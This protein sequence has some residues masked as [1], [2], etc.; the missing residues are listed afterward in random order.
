[1]VF[2]INSI[3]ESSWLEPAK[4]TVPLGQRASIH[5]SYPKWPTLFSR[6]H[7]TWDEA[8]CSALTELMQAAVTSNHCGQHT[9]NHET[10]PTRLTLPDLPSTARLT[11]VSYSTALTLPASVLRIAG[12][13][14][15]DAPQ[16]STEKPRQQAISPQN[17]CQSCQRASLSRRRGHR[18]FLTL[19]I[20]RYD[21]VFWYLAPHGNLDYI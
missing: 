7:P 15:G 18:K 3:A 5:K 2:L 8:Y 9:R 19:C 13:T 11:F 20:V 12:H 6:L 14:A 4:L 21:S 17:K 16:A 10:L 1:M